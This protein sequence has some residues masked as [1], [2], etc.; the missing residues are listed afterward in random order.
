M[1]NRTQVAR[2][3]WL[4]VV[5]L[6]LI[7]HFY[8]ASIVQA[9][10]KYVGNGTPESCTDAAL[11]NAVVGGGTIY[12]RCGPYPIT[13]AVNGGPIVILSNTTID[14]EDK[15][16]LSGSGVY[17]ILY[18]EYKQTLTLNRIVLKD[19][20]A[21]SDTPS[22][23]DGGGA[24]RSDG[25]S[26]LNIYNS[27]ILNSKFLAT[28]HGN[29]DESAYGGAIFI[30]DRAIMNVENS[31]FEGNVSYRG[32][33][34]AIHTIETNLTVRNS[35]FKNNVSTGDGSGAAI[36]NDNVV[37]SN[38]FVLVEDSYFEG[39]TSTGEGGAILTQLFKGNQ[40]GIYRRN[41]YIKN[42]VTR[43]P[44]GLANGGAIRVGDG[45]FEISD[46]FFQ[47]N[48]TEGQGGAIWVGETS[49]V[50]INGNVIYNNRAYKNTD[51]FPC[52]NDSR[53][54]AHG[55]GIY[56][57]GTPGDS[58][59]SAEIVNTLISENSAH[60]YGGGIDYNS[61]GPLSIINSTIVDNYVNQNGGGVS[62][63]QPSGGGN[64]TIKNSIIANNRVV[65]GGGS[66]TRYN[67][68]KSSGNF[69]NGGNN[70]QF[71]NLIANDTICASGFTIADPKVAGLADNGGPY[72]TRGLLP[73]SPAINAGNNNVCNAAPVN[74]KDIRRMF[75]I[76]S[77]IC[78]IGAFEVLA[79]LGFYSGLSS[80]TIRVGNNVT[81]KFTLGNPHYNPVTN[82]NFSQT[83]PAGLK[84]AANP[85][86]TNNCAI[87]GAVTATAGS[88]A[89]SIVGLGLAAN[90][91]CEISLQINGDLPGVYNLAP[92]SL[93]TKETAASSPPAA[94]S[95][96]VLALVPQMAINFPTSVIVSGT[97]TTLQFTI[98][99]TNK[100]SLPQIAFTQTLPTA[101]KI[102]SAPANAC[103]GTLTATVGS[104]QVKLA[105]ATLSANQSCNFSL[106]IMGT[107]PGVWTVYGTQPYA[108]GSGAGKAAKSVSL[109]VVVPR[110]T[111]APLNGNNVFRVG[112]A[113]PNSTVTS[114]LTFKNAGHALTTLTISP[115]ATLQAPFNVTGL[116]L[117][118]QGGTSGQ[119]DISCTP[120]AV[121][122]YNT[123]LNLV[124][125]DGGN[126]GKAL[127]LTLIC[128]GGYVVTK[129]NDDGTDGTLSY[130]L[131]NY[132]VN[133][134][135]AVVFQLT[136]SNV[137]TFS[138]PLTL[139]VRTG[140]TVDGG[141]SSGPGIIL[142]GTGINSNGL[143][144]TSNTFVKGLGIRNFGLLQLFGTGYNNLTQCVVTKK[145]N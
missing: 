100:V 96:T 101:L 112:A 127:N 104:S 106:T 99:N 70:I 113:A 83:L 132:A 53:T 17:R 85:A 86:L 45:T 130:A 135:D 115:T 20:W 111:A 79:P 34:G 109:E 108:P 41:K 126:S 61:P 124:T 66:T 93:T 64:V 137:I 92:G 120:P 26:T 95:L 5:P 46:S 3:A 125:N 107:A 37:D 145:N 116:P 57:Y 22:D 8:P 118:L 117:N 80:S 27:Q 2:Y 39:N 91:L 15:I 32:G 24:I 62:I 134:G 31:Y 82:V 47:E 52:T 30:H 25:L 87:P 81:Y 75:R 16:Q 48:S 98:S 102:S 4:F 105:N 94:L 18:V 77:G 56:I 138:N 11:R 1:K 14:G 129:N 40:Q 110:L 9:A 69:I 38:G 58:G 33:G 114:R 73:G 128:S 121:G 131:N 97:T 90:Q 63:S 10:T 119:V 28:N 54:S 36:Y 89:I 143:Q 51:P 133:A 71:S 72:P 123:T 78:D 43:D 12:F 140:V 67:C 74:Q 60:C 44:D 13:L 42:V 76:T 68:Y 59:N 141:C 122:S 49:R 103:G 142:D 6:A 35:I 19:G 29:E 84:I 50:K 65:A 21:R 55:G 7:I 139:T 23:P 136:G 88:T 144:L